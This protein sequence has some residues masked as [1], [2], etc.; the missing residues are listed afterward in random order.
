M[1][2]RVHRILIISG[3][4]LGVVMMIF[5]AIRWFG[6][7]DET[8]LPTGVIGLIAAVALSFYLRWFVRKG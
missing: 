3:I 5:S 6:R 4:A 7:G 1:L 2:K 8:M